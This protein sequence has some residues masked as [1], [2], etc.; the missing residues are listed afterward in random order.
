MANRQNVV[1]GIKFQSKSQV[2]ADLDNIIN[3]LNKNS[4]INVLFDTKQ[5]TK[6]L[7]D[8]SKSLDKISDKMATSFKNSNDNSLKSVIDNTEKATKTTKEFEK[9]LGIAGQGRGYKELQARALELQKTM[10]SL[11]KVNITRNATNGVEK[12][13]LTYNDKLG[14]TIKETMAWETKTN[15]AGNEITKTFKTIGTQVTDNISKVKQMN[16]KIEQTK[17][18]MQNKLNN[19][20]Q[21]NNLSNNSFIDPTVLSNLQNR[22]N[23]INTNTPEKEIKELQTTINN[24]G[25][26]NSGIVKV[27]SAISK[28]QDNLKAMKGKYGDLVGNSDSI[29]QLQK[30]EEEIN[31]LKRLLESLKGGEYINPQVISNATTQATIANRNLATAVRT[32]SNA[33]RTGQQDV[34]SFGDSLRRAFS[35]AGIYMSTY[36]VIQLTFRA[37]KDGISTVIEMDTALANLNKVVDLSKNQLNYMRDSA[38]SLGKELGQSSTDVA[39]AMAEFGRLYKDTDSIEKMTKVSILGSNVMDNTTPAEVAKSLTTIM[40]AMKKE[41][42]DS[43]SILDSMNEIKCVSP[44]TVMRK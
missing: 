6:S 36:Q 42:G 3:Y 32:S 17:L 22:L 4:K 28:M 24:L 41:V 38:I 31:K 13:V 34:I 33:L 2:K 15:K 26:S 9:S 43:M 10:E 1:I 21:L 5:A 23:A 39:S 7:N 37:I 20:T 29:N 12:A 19:S 16:E 18:S 25:S 8:F 35:N 14:N 44:Y 30:Y 40:T 27:Q 11:S